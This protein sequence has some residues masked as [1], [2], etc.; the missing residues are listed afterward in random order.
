MRHFVLSPT[1]HLVHTVEPLRLV[2]AHVRVACLPHFH[3]RRPPFIRVPQA[4]LLV[5]SQGLLLVVASLPDVEAQVLPREQIF[6]K[7]ALQPR[8]PGLDLILKLREVFPEVGL[9]VQL[10]LLPPAQLRPLVVNELVHAVAQ[11][12][13]FVVL[14]VLSAHRGN[15]S[16]VRLLQ[17]ISLELCS[18]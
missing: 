9:L 5:P 6:A 15:Y 1:A 17:A 13:G 12:V 10:H 8:L 11:F 2:V 3:G 14:Y 4:L 7:D 18:D 16:L